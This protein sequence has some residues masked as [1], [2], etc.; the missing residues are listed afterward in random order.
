MGIMLIGDSSWIAASFR[1]RCCLNYI[2]PRDEYD[3][4]IWSQIQLFWNGFQHSGFRDVESPRWPS[5]DPSTL[6]EYDMTDTVEP[7]SQKLL[8][9]T[10]PLYMI[11]TRLKNGSCSQEQSISSKRSGTAVNNPRTQHGTCLRTGSGNIKRE[12]WDVVT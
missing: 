3:R 2:I 7:C 12:M 6:S 1:R 9:L 10:A 4:L 5:S 8:E 11:A